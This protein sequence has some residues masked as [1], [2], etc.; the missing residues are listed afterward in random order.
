MGRQPLDDEQARQRVPGGAGRQRRAGAAD[1]PDP[2]H[3]LSPRERE[4]LAL[5]AEGSSN[6][7]VARELSI[8]K[9]TVKI[10]VQHILRKLNLSSR[11]QAAVYLAGR[12]G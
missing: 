4:I 8:A 9:A 2:I 6:K 12:L 5:I 7:E 1:R 3:S 11:V 10:H